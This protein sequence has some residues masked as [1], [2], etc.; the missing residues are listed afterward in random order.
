MNQGLAGFPPGLF[1]PP[2]RLLNVRLF[3]TGT[4]ITLHPL[5]RYQQVFL[6]GGGGGAATNQTSG[7]N[8]GPGGRGWI[9]LNLPG[10]MAIPCAIGAAGATG[11]GSQTAGSDTWLGNNREFGSAGGGG[12]RGTAGTGTT[13]STSRL[14]VDGSVGPILSAV[15]GGNSNNNFS[16][17]VPFV[18]TPGRGAI[19]FSSGGCTPHSYQYQASQGCIWLWEY[20]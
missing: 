20:A 1:M 14:I 5:S 16:I 18:D 10:G 17:G 3:T 6:C 9:A 2:G 13:G 7:V 19:G 11:P 15:G 4:Q 12:A 8:G